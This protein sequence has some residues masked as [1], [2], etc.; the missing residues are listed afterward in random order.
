MIA[1]TPEAARDLFE[2]FRSAA[3]LGPEAASDRLEATVG[4]PGFPGGLLSLPLA[5]GGSHFYAAAR[6]PADWRRLRP[7]LLSFAG[8]TLTDFRGAQSVL[9]SDLPHEAVLANAGLAA[10]ARLAAPASTAVSAARALQRLA[11]LVARTPQ[12]SRPAPEST[13]RLLARIQDHLNALAIDDAHRLLER[14]RAEHRLDALNLRFLEIEILATARDWPGIVALPF[15]DDVLQTRR[16]PAISAALLEALYWTSFCG[17]EGAPSYEGVLRNRVRTLVR[18][19]PIAGLGAGGWRLHGYEA[20]ASEPPNRTLVASVLASSADL[21]DLRS[22][23]EAVIAQLG[24]DASVGP[25]TTVAAAVA[26]AD[27]AGTLSAFEQ[28]QRL[29]ASL[30][31]A[32]Q[33]VL[34]GSAQPRAAV[35]AMEATFGAD[36]PPTN[37]GEWLYRIQAPN[38]TTALTVARRGATEWAPRLGDPVEITELAEQLNAA[39]DAP[40][41]GDRLVEALPHFVSWLLRDPDFPRAAGAPVYEAALDRV[42]LS[43]RSSMPLLDSAAMLARALLELGPTPQG[44]R[45]LL[46]DLLEIAGDAAGVR[47]AY[48]LIELLE[49]TVAQP[50]ADQEARDQFWQGAL[51]R[52]APIVRQL[53]VLQRLSLRRLAQSTGWSGTFEDP[54]EAP[55]YSE[56]D[57][58]L[59]A[60]LAGKIV[61]IYTLTE[62]AAVQAAEVLRQIAPTVDVRVNSEFDNSR[63]LRSLAENA[64]LFVLVAASATH[65]ATDA[66]RMRRGD[67]PLVYAAGKGSISI[68]RAVEEW[69]ARSG[70]AA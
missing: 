59:T 61:A 7:L 54:V 68:L 25:E 30:S 20:L 49:T 29:I 62:S 37:W 2:A 67:A 4:D 63:T 26:E 1:D 38:F 40:P 35:A 17:P 55:G 43:G 32:E 9:R 45:R 14:C 69:A 44:Y 48:W 31:D 24:P 39:P 64:D 47:T 6:T 13:G 23:L 33:E 5:D 46:A 18:Q 28:V 21:G 8:P 34:L 51:A 41:Y 11:T 42:L 36:L 3:G 22:S 27:L 58:G 56:T 10:V 65:A 57:A 19:P 66:I 52:L 50:A 15:F 12:D 60:R 53:S 70:A 16:P